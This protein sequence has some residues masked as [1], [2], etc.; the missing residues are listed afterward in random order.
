MKTSMGGTMRLW[1]C[2][3]AL[4]LYCSIARAHSSACKCSG[5]LS[6][7]GVFGRSMHMPFRGAGSAC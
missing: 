3:S 1:N 2:A 5:V 6:K 4:H 7:R